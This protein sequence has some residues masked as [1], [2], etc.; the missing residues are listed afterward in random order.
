M[1]DPS[2]DLQKAVFDALSEEEVCAGAIFWRVPPKQ[3]LPF[4]LIGDDFI[5]G[6]REAGDHHR[7]TVNVTLY[8]SGKPEVKRE[9][10]KVRKALDRDFPIDNFRIYEH[11]LERVFYTTQP[12]GLTQQ[13]EAAFTFLI[14][15]A[16]E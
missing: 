4:C 5:E 7:A 3:A 8:A 11:E 14:I 9:F 1:I 15:P 12:D 2:Y 16:S 6:D 10:A 13:A